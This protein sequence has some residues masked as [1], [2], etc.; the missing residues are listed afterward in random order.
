MAITQEICE[1]LHL[2]NLDFPESLKVLSQGVEDYGDW[3]GDEALRIMV[4]IDDSV[5]EFNMSGAD[6]GK[7]HQEIHESLLARGVHLFPY[8]SLAKPSE[9]QEAPDEE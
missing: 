7:L 8:I 2:K 4:L 6:V 9:L 5:D 3:T 1:A